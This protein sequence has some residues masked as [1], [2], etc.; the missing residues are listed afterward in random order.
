MPDR[1]LELSKCPR[2]KVGTSNS[3]ILQSF[4]YSPMVAER[5][6]T[7]MKLGILNF[8]AAAGIAPGEVVIHYLVASVDPQDAVARRGEELSRKRYITCLNICNI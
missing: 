2:P 5:T 6:L 8:T 4:R 1:C 3:T 7:N